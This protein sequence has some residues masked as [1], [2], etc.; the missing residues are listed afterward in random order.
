MRAASIL[1]DLAKI[2]QLGKGRVNATVGSAL[3]LFGG[4]L[5]YRELGKSMQSDTYRAKSKQR[6]KK[7]SPYGPGSS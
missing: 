6:N 7:G 4:T 2:E 5:S 3:D 1:E